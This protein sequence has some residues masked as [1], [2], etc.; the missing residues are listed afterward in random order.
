MEYYTLDELCIY[1]FKYEK[2]DDKI[3]PNVKKGETIV[4]P[5]TF[6]DVHVY[7]GKLNTGSI[8]VLKI[9]NLEKQTMLS[10]V[11]SILK[12]ERSK[13]MALLLLNETD[14][15]DNANKLNTSDIFA[16]ILSRRMTIDIFSL[17]DEQLMDNFMLGQCPQGRSTRLLQI[18]E[19]TVK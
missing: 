15:Y 16:T 10:K 19:L 11:I 13:R 6:R 2:I 18:L 9:S 17:L 3:V 8:S 4:S 5:S 12:D 7:D 14:N 1:F